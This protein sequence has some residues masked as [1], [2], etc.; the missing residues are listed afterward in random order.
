MVCPAE[1]GIAGRFRPTKQRRFLPISHERLQQRRPKSARRTAFREVFDSASFR[2][3]VENR[4]IFQ[5]ASRKV[6]GFDVEYLRNGLDDVSIFSRRSVA[7][8]GPKKPW[9]F[10]RNASFRFLFIRDKPRNLR[11]A[12]APKLETYE[13]CRRNLFCSSRTALSSCKISDFSDV[14]FSRYSPS[15]LDVSTKNRSVSPLG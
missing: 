10:E 15:K 11:D 9:Q 1:H 2:S 7:T 13:K 6:V 5:D 3:S 4:G 8:K 12:I 14:P